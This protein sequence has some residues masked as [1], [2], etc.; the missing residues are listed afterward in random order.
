MTT[1]YGRQNLRNVSI[2]SCLADQTDEEKAAIKAIYDEAQNDMI[3]KC[4]L[5]NRLIPDGK[6]HV[7]HITPLSRG[8]GHVASNLAIAH[9]SCNSK[10]GNKTLEEYLHPDP[11]E[12]LSS[13]LSFKISRNMKRRLDA[14]LDETGMTVSAYLRSAICEYLEKHGA[15]E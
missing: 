4:Y 9:Q 6:R 5:C 7:D 2:I 12:T 1:E 15:G 3:V 8:G 14:R 10:K 13:L 11:K